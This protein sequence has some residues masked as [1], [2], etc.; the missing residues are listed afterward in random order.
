LRGVKLPIRV[1]MPGYVNRQKLVRI[2]AGI[3]LGESARFL[4]R[5]RNWLLKLF[6]PG[7]YSPDRLIEGLKPGFADSDSNV[8]GLHVYT[9]N[10]VERT[11]AWRR[12]MLERAETSA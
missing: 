10:E 7:G 5:Q 3:G 4:N 6:M 11:E 12:E 8:Q 1:G 9:F 2:S